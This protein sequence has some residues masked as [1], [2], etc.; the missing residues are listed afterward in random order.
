MA[1]LY[2]IIAVIA[3]IAA[4]VFINIDVYFDIA[5]NSG[6]NRGRI[7]IK[8]GFIRFNILPQRSKHEKKQEE[9][10]EELTKES[11]KD[12][13]HIIKFAKAVYREEKEDILKIL[14]KLLKKAIRIK[15]LN[16][17]SEF[18]TGDPMY[19]GIATG[20]VNAAV[21]SGISY[22]DRNMKIDSWNVSLTPNFDDAVIKAGIFT[23]IR[24]NIFNL[25]SIIWKAV[26]LILKIEKINRR[27]SENG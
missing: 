13:E 1:A 2:I 18:G 11:K 20:M 16:I 23:K 26:F 6:V 3:V 19:T 7:Y 27:I 15:E 9:E 10:Q 25:I 5:Y 4:F 12:T 14:E 8:Y 21:Y 17:S 22:I 24:T